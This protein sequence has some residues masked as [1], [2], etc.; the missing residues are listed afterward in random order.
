MDDNNN[1]PYGYESAPETAPEPPPAPEPGA[2]G[3]SA[4]SLGWQ[5]QPYA[6]GAQ[7]FAP[8]PAYQ[9]QPY[10]PPA[11]QPAPQPKKRRGGLVVFSVFAALAL[12]VGIFVGIGVYRGLGP[13][14]PAGDDSRLQ[15]A[16]PPTGSLVAAPDG[17]LNPVQINEKLRNSNVAVQLYSGRGGDRVMGEGSGII[18]HE[19]SAK[20]YTY[21]LTCA[22]VINEGNQRISVELADGASYDAAIV[23]YDNRTDVG[24]LRI[25][26]TGLSGAEFG[27]SDLLRVGEAVYAIGNPGGV[28]FKGSFTNGIVSAIERP[29]QSSYKMQTIQHTA[30]INMG[31]SGGALVNAYGQVV[32]VNSAKIMDMQY[33]GMGFAIP[34]KVVQKVVNDLIAKGYVP[35]RPKLGIEYIAASRTQRGMLVMR[36]NDLPSGSLIIAT[37]N[38]DSDIA[39]TDIRANDIITHVNGEPLDKAAVLLEV[40]DKG[41]VG[42][43]IDLTIA[44]VNAAD[45]SVKSFDVKV[46]LVEDKGNAAP[47][48]EERPWY[49]DD[50]GDDFGGYGFPPGFPWDW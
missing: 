31:N 39:G 1:F 24:L 15:L 16:Q 14:G 47:A 37:I 13:G 17:T 25:K 28:E 21:V 30:P 27:D 20:A 42:Q 5:P 33:E 7:N 34:S 11:Y 50:D 19:D 36:I 3:E 4:D 32:G 35:D 22:H 41:K 29:L 49:E 38:E 8:P 40:I 26:A 44:R 23:G 18:L 6:Y 12:V 43:E 9:P 46:K 10:Y 48:Q 45:Y 2:P